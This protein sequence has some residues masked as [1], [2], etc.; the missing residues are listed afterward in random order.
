MNISLGAQKAFDKIQYPFMI[1]VLEK[2]G[3]QGTNLNIIKIIYRKLI[4]NIKLNGV[5]V[6][7]IPLIS[8]TIL[9]CLLS[10]YL[11]NIVLEVLMEQ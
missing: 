10:K 8:G 4:G 9:G 6:K 7:A 11:F 1:K 3:I 2:S 5:K